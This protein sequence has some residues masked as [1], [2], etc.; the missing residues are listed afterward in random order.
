MLM[1]YTHAH[2]GVEE[3]FWYSSRVMTVS[4]HQFSAGFFP[5]H[6]HTTHHPCTY[7]HIHTHMWQDV[8]KRAMWCYMSKKFFLDILNPLEL[9][10][11]TV[12]ESLE[13]LLR[14][15]S[16][17]RSRMVDSKT[18]V[19]RNGSLKIYFRWISSH[20]VFSG[21]SVFHLDVIFNF[22]VSK[23]SWMHALHVWREGIPHL[24]KWFV[25][26]SWLIPFT[27]GCNPLAK[28]R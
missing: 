25:I 8:R 3:A 15:R 26:N 28:V 10:I 16:Y 13:W 20:S 27:R 7:L 14:S 23:K 11:T 22:V 5:G 6:L 17:E 19:S 9:L 21:K 24:R 1:I 4:F 2:T 18:R 12:L